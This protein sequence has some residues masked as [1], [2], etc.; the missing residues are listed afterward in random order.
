MFSATDPARQVLGCW[1][2]CSPSSLEKA[3]P[4]SM[5]FYDYNFV[6]TFRTLSTTLATAF[7]R[8]DPATSSWPVSD[9]LGSR[10]PEEVAVN[11]SAPSAPVADVKTIDKGL[12]AKVL[13]RRE[14]P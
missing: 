9:Y 3:H 13:S 14:L 12:Q 1:M 8:F 5:S 11:R 2:L 10:R 7:S 4:S 6:T